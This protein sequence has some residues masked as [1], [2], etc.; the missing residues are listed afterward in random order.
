MPISAVQSII[1]YQSMHMEISGAGAASAAH[2][3]SGAS[4]AMSPTQKM[5]N[6]FDQ[7]DTTGSGTIT[8]SQF[9]QA[10]QQLN[11]PAS[12][13]TAGADAVWSQLDPSGTGSVSAPDFTSGMT[14]LMKSL[15]GWNADSP[16]G[17]QAL[18]Q[19]AN[20]LEGLGA[21]GPSGS[22]LNLVA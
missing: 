14:S 8:Q 17:A 4:P 3:A 19:S 5:S 15:R 18:G 21:A 11:P 6:L 2:A 13:Q 22:S 12:F 10:F 7:I 20:T 1:V 16:A 9:A